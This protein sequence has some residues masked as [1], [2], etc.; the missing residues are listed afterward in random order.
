[1]KRNDQ[2]N[3]AANA[4]GGTTQVP[5]HGVIAPTAFV[6]EIIA[7]ALMSAINGTYEA[8]RRSYWERKTRVA[9][10]DLDDAI[11]RDIGVTRSEIPE[12]ARTAVGSPAHDPARRIPW[13]A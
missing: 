1:M 2:F 6:S 13:G 4:G 3:E 11:L 10:S 7:T 5:F 8:V 12:V 9:L